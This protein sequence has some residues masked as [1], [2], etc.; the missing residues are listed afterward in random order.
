MAAPMVDG[1]DLSKFNYTTLVP[2]NETIATGGDS[3]HQDL[4]VHYN[5]LYAHLKEARLHADCVF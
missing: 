4:N 2:Y 3:L 1:L 5:V